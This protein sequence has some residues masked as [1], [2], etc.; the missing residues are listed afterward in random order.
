M[1]AALNGVP[2]LSTLDGWWIEGWIEGVTGWAIDVPEGN[3][4][5]LGAEIGARVAC[6]D[7]RGSGDADDAELLYRV[8]EA[9]VAPTYYKDRDALT[10]M[11]RHAVA[12]NASFF[13]A[14]RM[15]DEYARRAYRPALHG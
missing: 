13:S 2:S 4:R 14:H 9:A 3:P 10:A 8:L 11:G 7:P 6:S 15:V 12:L 5:D 1:K